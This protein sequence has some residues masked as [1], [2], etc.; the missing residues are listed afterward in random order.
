MEMITVLKTNKLSAVFAKSLYG[1]A[2]G[3]KGETCFDVWV[4]YKKHATDLP[5]NNGRLVVIP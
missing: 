5:D 1:K 3:V 2:S 4:E